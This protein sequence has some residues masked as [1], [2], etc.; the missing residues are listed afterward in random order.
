MLIEV[1]FALSFSSLPQLPPA[2]AAA[3][4]AAPAGSPAAAP[5]V[6]GTVV[7]ADGV[8]VRYHVVTVDLA[9]HAPLD[10]GP[11]EMAPA[12]PAG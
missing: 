10:G 3:D 4:R 7:T 8:K 9:G 2:P 6:E 11:A 12:P 1:A 5:Q